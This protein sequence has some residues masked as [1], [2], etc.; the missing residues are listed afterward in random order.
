MSGPSYLDGLNYHD[1]VEIDLGKLGGAV[2]DWKSTV[3]GLKRLM[4]DASSGL[5]KKSE[6]A[7]WV[8]L[9]ADVTREFVKKT[10]EELMDLHQEANAIWNVLDDAHS[11]LTEIQSNIKSIVEQA[12]EVKLQVTDNWDGT[13][14]FVYPFEMDPDQ[15][16][17][18][19]QHEYNRRVNAK[20]A[21]AIR[22]DGLVKGALAKMHGGDPY[23]AGH[24]RYDSLD[25]V[26]LDRA[27]ALASLGKD[28]NPKQRAELRKLWDALSPELRGQLWDADRVKLMDTGVISPKY[29]WKSTVKGNPGW[30]WRDPTAGDRWTLF[31]AKSKVAWDK[32][33]G[34]SHGGQALE[35]YLSHTGT[36]VDDLD[37]DSMLRDD[38]PMYE[39]VEWAIV[40]HQEKWAEQ[41]RKELDKSGGQTVTVPVETKGQ[42]FGFGNQ[43]WR[44]AVGTGTFNVSGAMTARLNEYGKPEYYLDYQVNVWDRYSHN[45]IELNLTDPPDPDL[46]KLQEAGLAEDFDMR[47]SSSVTHY[48]FRQPGPDGVYDG[49]GPKVQDRPPPAGGGAKYVRP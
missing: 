24:T 1:M 29:K 34:L 9:N 38:K 7:R 27:M 35:H 8:G 22:I 42:T 39:D 26:A 3:D 47:G 5:L 20:M 17:R 4:E 41:A 6:G 16:D 32:L 30:A 31:E 44:D 18:D 10:A 19:V 15:H 46:A 43:D 2:A 40:D 48:D 28:V 21:R 33:N 49:P 23:D 37:V 36:P 13:V 11:Q 25:D 14:K 12:K 45:E